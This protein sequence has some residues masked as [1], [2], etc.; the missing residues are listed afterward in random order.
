MAKCIALGADLAAS[1]RPLLQ[2]LDR[3]GIAGA[4]DV[5][6]P[7]GAAELRGAMFLTG[8]RTLDDLRQARLVATDGILTDT[9][10]SGGS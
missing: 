4:P 10:L 8:S 7:T 5:S 6:W 9:H 3:G 2:A 1:A